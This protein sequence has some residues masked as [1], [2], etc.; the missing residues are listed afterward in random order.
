MKIPILLAMLG[1]AAVAIDAHTKV[2]WRGDFDT[3]DARQWNR[4]INPAG[5]SVVK[6]CSVDGAYAGKVRLS[7]DD[8]FLW[9][10]DKALNRSEFH[11]RMP[12]G[13]THEGRDTY[14]AFSFYLPKAFSAHKHELGYWE[15]DRTWRQMLRFNI[16]GSALSFQ[17]SSAAGAFWTIADGASPGR[18]HRIALHIHWSV[19][20]A[21]GFAHTWVDG[22]DMG[23]HRLRTL[24]AEDALM[25][26]QIGV[27]RTQEPATETILIDAAVETDNLAELLAQDTTPKTATCPG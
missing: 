25:F 14:F 10:G 2:L 27:L 11:H 6:G 17:Q 24:P 12:D 22:S 16:R 3:G 26:T 5:L 23:V 18:W 4:P 7:G 1:M 19:D 13:A 15:S 21:K 8:A 20:A 9:N